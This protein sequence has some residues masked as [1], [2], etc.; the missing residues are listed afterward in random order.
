MLSYT[1][2][3]HAPFN[4]TTTWNKRKLAGEWKELITEPTYKGDKTECSN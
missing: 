3:K 2:K 1:F 4:F